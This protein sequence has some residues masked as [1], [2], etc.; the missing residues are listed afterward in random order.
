MQKAL[1]KEFVS[2]FTFYTM[3]E[4]K[5]MLPAYPH[6]RELVNQDLKSEVN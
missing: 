5:L 4:L 6:L 1:T 3:Y 2:A